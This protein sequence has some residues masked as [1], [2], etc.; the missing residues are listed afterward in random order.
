MF[1]FKHFTKQ[2]KKASNDR[3]VSSKSSSMLPKINDPGGSKVVVSR[4]NVQ[5]VPAIPLSKND[6][7]ME[8]ALSDRSHLTRERQIV[9][10]PNDLFFS[11]PD[12]WRHPVS[13]PIRI[14][15]GSK[16]NSK[17][18]MS[19]ESSSFGES[20]EGDKVS[21]ITSCL[22]ISE[23][24]NDSPVSQRRLARSGRLEFPQE[25]SSSVQ[26]VEED[27]EESL[28][29]FDRMMSLSENAGKPKEEK[30]NSDL[31]TEIQFK[32]IR[33]LGGN[34]GIFIGEMKDPVCD[35]EFVT[36][37]IKR[38]NFFKINK[39]S[40]YRAVHESNIQ[41]FL[42]D[43]IFSNKRGHPHIVSF[44]DHALVKQSNLHFIFMEYCK[45]GTL[46]DF[47]VEQPLLATS[48]VVRL[49]LY[50]IALGLKYMHK[51]NIAHRDL[52]LENI[53]LTWNA[54]ARRVIAKI[55]DFGHACQIY[56]ETMDPYTLCSPDYAAPELF[57]KEMHNS[58]HGD[59]WSYGVCLFSAFERRFPFIITKERDG[60]YQLPPVI[61]H[62]KNQIR[63]LQFSWMDTDDDFVDLVLKLLVYEPKDRLGIKQVVDHDFFKGK[64]SPLI[65]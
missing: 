3:P 58:L 19:S 38:Q 9:G 5:I 50:D 8:K 10:D 42:S 36:V 60:T 57:G 41:R 17:R 30:S 40:N 43:P 32:N 12:V 25:A 52:K 44:I 45:H 24:K 22:A 46:L 54:N 62:L 61:E 53:F 1:I 21:H 29:P 11:A 6:K 18:S 59:R 28:S 49:L 34:D 15:E 33:P 55:G 20:F 65:L 39:I 35:D 47:I 37:V 51:K 63:V 64:L 13:S 14:P 26:V 48:A 56:E 2:S 27:S 4:K 23:K 7:K 16:R 31:N